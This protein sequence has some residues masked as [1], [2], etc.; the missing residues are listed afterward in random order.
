MR[1]CYGVFCTSEGLGEIPRGRTPLFVLELWNMFHRTFH[2]LP[3]NITALKGGIGALK[4]GI[5]ALKGGIGALK[6]GIGALK[7][8]IGALKGGIGALKGGIGALKGGIGAFKPVSLNATQYMIIQIWR[9][10]DI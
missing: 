4:G 5:G 7:G 8:G 3:R 1:R 10:C 2:E 6:G 9:L